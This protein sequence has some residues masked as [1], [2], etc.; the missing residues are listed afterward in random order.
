[1]FENKDL[2]S[3]VVEDIKIDEAIVSYNKLKRARTKKV[4]EIK[5]LLRKYAPTERYLNSKEICEFGDIDKLHS[6]MTSKSPG[7]R[8]IRP[9]SIKDKH[10]RERM[11][12][13]IAPYID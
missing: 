13:F 4:A 8:A 12:K 6:Q 2:E 3:R 11:E 5:E 10:W 9:S 7:E 1:M